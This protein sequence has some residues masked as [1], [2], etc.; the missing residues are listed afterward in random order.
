MKMKMN[1]ILVS[2]LASL[3]AMNS[4]YSYSED[5]ITSSNSSVACYSNKADKCLHNN[6]ELSR[7]EYV[8]LI[9]GQEAFVTQVHYFSNRD[10]KVI[11]EYKTEESHFNQSVINMVSTYMIQNSLSLSVIFNKNTYLNEQKVYVRQHCPI[12]NGCQTS[13]DFINNLMVED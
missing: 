4:T 3:F 2:A 12:S 11:L 5:T 10:D 1:K 7:N 8:S 9:A 13:M 6:K